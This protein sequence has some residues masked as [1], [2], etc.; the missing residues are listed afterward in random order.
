MAKYTHL[1]PQ[2]RADSSVRK[3][4][5]FSPTGKQ[6]GTIPLGRLTMSAEVEKQYSFGALS[7]VHITKDT[8]TEDFQ[9]A[10][11]YLNNDADVAFT[12]I[13]GDLTENG[14]GTEKAAESCS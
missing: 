7:D 11:S 9:K 4:A 10:L 8:A 1:I 6:V 3:I 2:N 14:S 12:C 13:C 5:V